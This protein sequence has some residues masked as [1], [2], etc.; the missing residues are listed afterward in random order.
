MTGQ[1]CTGGAASRRFARGFSGGAASIL[2]GAV[3]ALLPKCPLCLAAWL[4]ITTGTAFPVAGAVWVRGLLVASWI[5]GVAFVL[6]PVAR[7]LRPKIKPPGISSG[8]VRNLLSKRL[9]WC[10]RNGIHFS[11]ACQPGRPI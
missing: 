8:R 5:A 10:G 3:L 2:P 6:A 11:R 9:P 7:R 1:C 4:T